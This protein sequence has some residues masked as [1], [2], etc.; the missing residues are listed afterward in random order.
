MSDQILNQLEETTRFLN[1][2]LDYEVLL[3][4]RAHTDLVQQKHQARA[5]EY[6]K[7]LTACMNLLAEARGYDEHQKTSA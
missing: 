1:G 2:C 7:H 4:D 3:A 5:Y 6:R